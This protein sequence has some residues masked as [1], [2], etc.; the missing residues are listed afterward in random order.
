MLIVSSPYAY[1]M[2]VCIYIY[3]YVCIYI[4]R[5]NSRFKVIT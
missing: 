2:H 4:L 5:P 1:I 3:V